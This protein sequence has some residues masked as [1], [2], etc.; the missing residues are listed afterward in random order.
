MSLNSSHPRDDY[1]HAVQ[2]AA[3]ELG[4]SVQSDSQDG[5]AEY[6]TE[7]PPSVFAKFFI[8]HSNQLDPIFMSSALDAAFDSAC[9]LDRPL[10][11]DEMEL[12][13]QAITAGSNNEWACSVIERNIEPTGDYPN[14]VPIS[15]LIKSTIDDIEQVRKNAARITDPT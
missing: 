7:H 4:I 9:H 5:L 14:E 15:E 12:L 3:R 11:T 10:S 8:E 6:C 2:V 13:R 1:R